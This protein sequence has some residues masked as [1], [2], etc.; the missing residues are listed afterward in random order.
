VESTLKQQR[1]KT[2]H[3]RGAARRKVEGGAYVM[4]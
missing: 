2:T 4:T 1:G 3:A